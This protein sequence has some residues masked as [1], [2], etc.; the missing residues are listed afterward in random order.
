[1]DYVDVVTKD[2]AL[3]SVPVQIAPT[4][5]TAMVEILSGIAAGDTV[6]AASARK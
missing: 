2:K 6:F 4:A 1:M 3:S 5:D